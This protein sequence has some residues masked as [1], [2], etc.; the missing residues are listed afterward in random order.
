MEA[1][2][3]R[4]FPLLLWQPDALERF[5]SEAP[6]PVNALKSPEART[7]GTPSNCALRRPDPRP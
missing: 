3:N 5:I 4:V 1:G 6:G 7:R 2:A